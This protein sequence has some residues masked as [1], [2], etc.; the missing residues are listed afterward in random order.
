MRNGGSVV[1]GPLGLDG[2]RTLPLWCLLKKYMGVGQ[3]AEKGCH[4]TYTEA[5]KEVKI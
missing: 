4:I 3:R 2:P 1:S 5:E